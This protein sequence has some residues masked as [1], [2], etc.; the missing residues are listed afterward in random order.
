MKK[1]VKELHDEELQWKN[2]GED[3]ALI[4]HD[5][6]EN[7]YETERIIEA[8]ELRIRRLQQLGGKSVAIILNHVD[9][10]LYITT[11]E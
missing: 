7:S 8:I 11:N 5:I 2:N 3:V 1:S 4:I 10:K 6:L 9:N